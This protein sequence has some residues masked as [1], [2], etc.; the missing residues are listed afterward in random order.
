M[1][2]LASGPIKDTTKKTVTEDD[3]D[4]RELADWAS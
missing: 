4:L 3:D 1:L 2:Y